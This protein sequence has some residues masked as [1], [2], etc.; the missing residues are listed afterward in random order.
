M[1]I[2]AVCGSFHRKEVEKMLEFARD[3]ASMMNS[4]LTDIVWVPDLWKH[5][6]LWK[7]SSSERM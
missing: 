3:E 6:L 2:V 1:R 7:D 4:E 5:L